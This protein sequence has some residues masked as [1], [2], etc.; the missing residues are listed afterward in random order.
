[1]NLTMPHLQLQ[2]PLD[3][4]QEGSFVLGATPNEYVLACG[5]ALVRGGEGAR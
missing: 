3:E 1:V 4:F 2:C 5:R